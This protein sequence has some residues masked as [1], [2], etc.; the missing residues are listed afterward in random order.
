MRGPTKLPSE[1]LG[2]R[3]GITPTET[4]GEK[5]M[6]PAV[7]V[8][9]GSYDD[10]PVPV[11]LRQFPLIAERY[12]ERWQALRRAKVEG[13]AI[14]TKWAFSQRVVLGAWEFFDREGWSPVTVGGQD[15]LRMHPAFKVLTE[16][17]EMIVRA[18]AALLAL[19]ADPMRPS[20]TE[21]DKFN[22]DSGPRF[23]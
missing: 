1:L 7:L 4:Q 5:Q 15:Q 14:L 10:N 19:L 23:E 9:A 20:F 8:D 6:S 13:D 22:P 21:W 18:D 16:A 2:E 12:L 11:F 3:A 17:L